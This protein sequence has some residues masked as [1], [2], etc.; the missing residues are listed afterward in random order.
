MPARFLRVSI[1]AFVVAVGLGLAAPAIGAQTNPP[2]TTAA[3]APTTTNYLEQTNLFAQNKIANMRNAY[4]R[5]WQMWKR[6][7]LQQK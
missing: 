4:E 1:A 6:D 3:P 2:D 7:A 5:P